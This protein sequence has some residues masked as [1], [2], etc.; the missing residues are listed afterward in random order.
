MNTY[1]R[2]RKLDLPALTCG[3]SYPKFPGFLNILWFINIPWQ[4][5]QVKTEHWC[6]EW[7]AAL[8]N[9]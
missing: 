9:T 3:H 7:G 4:L 1:L 5:K 2:T 8:T 6:Q